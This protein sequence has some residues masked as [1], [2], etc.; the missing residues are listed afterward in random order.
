MRER[1]QTVFGIMEQSRACHVC[2][3]NG[4]KIIEKCNYCH[5][6]GFLDEKIEKT[7]EVPPGIENGMSIKLRDEGHG[8]RDGNGDLYVSFVV[9]EKE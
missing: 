1:V 6:N 5:G 8:G 4:E 9:P 7:I 2:H 3:G